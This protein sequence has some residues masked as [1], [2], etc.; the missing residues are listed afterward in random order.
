MKH[1]VWFDQDHNALRIR[2]VGLCGRKDVVELGKIFRELMDKKETRRA[3]ID[4]SD[5]ESFP[6]EDV[7]E[8]LAD[9]TQAAGFSKVAVVGSRPEVK[10][11]GRIMIERLGK[12]VKTEF[13]L[14][15]EQAIK[16]LNGS[17]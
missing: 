10:I 7:R 13:F 17:G 15:E 6:D 9:E 1:R 4:L 14:N 16:W 11:V 3:L 12:Q 2:F 8:Q 5:I